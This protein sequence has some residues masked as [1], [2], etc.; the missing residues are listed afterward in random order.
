MGFNCLIPRPLLIDTD[1]GPTELFPTLWRF[2]FVL[3][4][5]INQA[6]FGRKT[7]VLK[8]NVFLG[9]LLAATGMSW[10]PEF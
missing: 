6:L 10:S 5:D 3:R 4:E 8:L 1:V 7:N 2:F 9:R